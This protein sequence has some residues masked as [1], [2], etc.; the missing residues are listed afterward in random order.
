MP[1]KTTNLAAAL[2]KSEEPQRPANTGSSKAASAP[3]TG[4]TPARVG[5]ASIGGWFDVSVKHGLDELRLRQAR[6][7]GG[8][9]TVQDLLDEA[10]N[11]L[12][13]KYGM[14]ELAPGRRGR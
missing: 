10:I 3:Q 8:R 4:R 13:K 14:P 9:V 5:K 6:E 1:K 7:Q 11:D 12:F 2:A